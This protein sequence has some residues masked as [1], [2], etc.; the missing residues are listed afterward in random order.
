MVD[1]GEDDESLLIAGMSAPERV[2]PGHM[3]AQDAFVTALFV[4]HERDMVG[5]HAL[6][7]SGDQGRERMPSHGFMLI[8]ECVEPEGGRQIHDGRSAVMARH[9]AQT[10]G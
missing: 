2:C 8:G 5:D 10:R 4:D 1:P 9:I 7:R 3:G 6:S